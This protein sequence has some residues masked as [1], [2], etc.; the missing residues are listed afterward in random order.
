MDL[1][2]LVSRETM[3]AVAKFDG[4]VSRETSPSFF[5]S[6]KGKSNLKAN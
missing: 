2:K 1:S 6:K 4:L 3:I 5:L